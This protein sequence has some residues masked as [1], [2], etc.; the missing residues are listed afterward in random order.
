MAGSAEELA[1]SDWYLLMQR[2][3]VSLE[4]YERLLKEQTRFPPESDAARRINSEL[5]DAQTE[6]EQ[7]KL[8]IASLVAKNAS[9]RGVRSPDSLIVGV[10][11]LN[12]DAFKDTKAAPTPLV[13]NSKAVSSK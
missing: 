2:W 6:L 10:V 1:V 11:E 7:I 8:E 5:E 4:N 13:R 3:Q 9:R 12:D